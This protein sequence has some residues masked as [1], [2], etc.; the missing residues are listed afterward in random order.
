MTRRWPAMDD[1]R[2]TN[3][4]MAQLVAMLQDA[5]LVEVYGDDEGHESYRLTADGVR[6]EHM[7]AM[8]DVDEAEALLELLLRAEADPPNR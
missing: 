1:A 3:A 4:E 5:G 8:G 6:G 2:P 7:L